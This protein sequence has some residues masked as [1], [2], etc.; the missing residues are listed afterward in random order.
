MKHFLILLCILLMSCQNS[1]EIKEIEILTYF[2]NARHFEIYSNTTKNGFT[3]TLF[4]SQ[5]SNFVDNYQTRINKRLMDSIVV[6]C[7]NKTNTDFV[8]K[9]SKKIWY[10][11]YWHKVQITYENGKTLNFTYPYSNNA[12]KQFIPFQLLSEQIKKDSLHATRLNIG[13]LGSLYLKQEDFSNA[14]FKEDSLFIQKKIAEYY[15]K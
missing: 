11:G 14:I 3:Q 15:T 4:K 9:T 1:N 7:K 8:F 5:T 6:I 10:C 12:N 13:Q 2:N